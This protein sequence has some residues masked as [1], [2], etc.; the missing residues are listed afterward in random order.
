MAFK[1]QHLFSRPVLLLVIFLG[2][3]IESWMFHGHFR[4]RPFAVSDLDT[5]FENSDNTAAA[6]AASEDAVAEAIADRYANIL[7]QKCMVKK[8]KEN[9]HL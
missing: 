5:D 8:S 3:G 9:S 7:G 1:P 6:A 4:P 2:S